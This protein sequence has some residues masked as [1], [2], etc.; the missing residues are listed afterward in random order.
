[1]AD[2]VNYYKNIGYFNTIRD[3]SGGKVWEYYDEVL[4]SDL[5]M[6]A[7]Q[8]Q[9]LQAIAQSE[10]TIIRFQGDN[11]YYDLYVTDMDKQIIQDTLDLY[12]ALL[13]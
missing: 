10:E 12:E 4:D 8:L 9:M 11:Y 3:N 13:G 5:S 6:D 1:M 2:G 7:G